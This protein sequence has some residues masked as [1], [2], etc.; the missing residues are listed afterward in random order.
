MYENPKVTIGK[1]KFGPVDLIIYKSNL[2]A[3]KKIQKKS[4][5]QPKRIEHVKQEKAILQMLNESKAPEADFIVKLEQTFTDHEFVC[6]VFEYL[7]GQDLFWV[8]VNE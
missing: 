2:F 5:D 6:F 7:P 8:L 3:L 4:I 1:G